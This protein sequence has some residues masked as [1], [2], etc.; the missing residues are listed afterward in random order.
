MNAVNSPTD[1][2]WVDEIELDVLDRSTLEAWATCPAQAKLMEIGGVIRETTPLTVGCEAH[3]VLSRALRFY[4]S[5]PYELTPYD[6][7]EELTRQML[8]SRPDLQPKVI[9]TLQRM[10][11]DW[12]RFVAQD[13]HHENILR[14]D[15]G[16]G[17]HS[18][19]LAYDLPSIGC[20]VTSELDLLCAG[21]SPDVLCEVDYKTG[22]TPYTAT[23]VKQSFQFQHHAALVLNT[24]PEVQALEVSVWVTRLNQ[25]THRVIF[26]R[27]HL[28]E[29]MS[30]VAKAAEL[31]MKFRRQLIERVPTWP[32]Q[33]KCGQC[34]VSHICPRLECRPGDPV[35]LLQQLIVIE[36]AEAEIRK[37]LIAT[38]KRTGQDVVTPAGDRFGKVG[39]KT[40]GTWKLTAAKVKEPEASE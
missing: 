40:D 39:P 22:N 35:G 4:L 2:S 36:N 38:V 5:D 31:A 12:V 29:Y 7:R 32:E 8:D 6:V 14:Y 26:D 16:T 11:Y 3:D 28:P 30:R 15:G 21:D 19:Q 33:D 18:G 37:Q 17:E 10:V 27:K 1:M 24:Y 25:R 13:M 9:E 23:S 20:R 34:Q